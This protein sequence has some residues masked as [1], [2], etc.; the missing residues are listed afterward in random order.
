MGSNTATDAERTP[1]G[2]PAAGQTWFDVIE[3]VIDTEIDRQE[4][5]QCRFEELEVDV[6]LR[7]EADAE[8]ARWRLDGTVRVHIEGTRGPLSE[9]LR[10][11]Y[12]R[13]S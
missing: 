13:L 8:I 4:T 6:P 2:R 9:W 12:S 3:D 1:V 5:I 10:F 11:W 7:M